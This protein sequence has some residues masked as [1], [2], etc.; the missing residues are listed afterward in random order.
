MKPKTIRFLLVEDD[1][2]HAA[3]ILRGLKGSRVPSLTN[4]VRDGLEALSYLRRKEPFADADRP[5]VVLLD[6]KLPKLS[7][8]EVLRAVK[9]DPDLRAI[10]VVVLTTSNADADRDQAYRLHAN[11][12]LVKPM[13]FVQFRQMVQDMNLYWGHW[14]QAAP[15]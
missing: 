4:R 8:H 5:D 13:D 10:P 15:S 1:D 11:S 6:L 12:Y 7:G 9:S 3:I 14:N 2:D